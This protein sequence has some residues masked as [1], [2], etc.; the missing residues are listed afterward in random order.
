MPSHCEEIKIEEILSVTLFNKETGEEIMRW[1][2]DA[3][4]SD[5]T[6]ANTD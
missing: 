6:S 3:G 4:G 1:D 2:F 5:A